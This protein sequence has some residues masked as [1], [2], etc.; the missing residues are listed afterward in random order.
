MVR[1][2]KLRKL[3]QK[4]KIILLTSFVFTFPGSKIFLYL[5][6]LK[7]KGCAT[8]SLHIIRPFPSKEIVD[9]RNSPASIETG[10]NIAKTF[11]LQLV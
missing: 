2:K 1:S 8:G 6:S 3:Y 4:Q 9:I 11:L 10:D 7:K 5:K